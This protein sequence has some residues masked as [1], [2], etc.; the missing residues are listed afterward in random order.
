VANAHPLSAPEQIY[1]ALTAGRFVEVEQ[2]YDKLMNDRTRD[3]RGEYLFEQFVSQTPVYSSDDAKSEDY[4]PKVD[5]LTARWL[6][7]SPNSVIAAITR[8]R[9]LLRRAEHLDATKGSW[10]DVDRLVTE[11][12]DVMARSR[13]RAAADPNWQALN[14]RLAR[15]AGV[16]H[17][18]IRELVRQ[19][20]SVDPYPVLLWEEAAVA[21][22]TDCSSTDNLL[23]LMRLAVERTG[24][25]EGTT[26]YAR[27]FEAAN[28]LYCGMENDPFGRGHLDWE[29][30]N[31]SLAELKVRYPAAYEPNLHG[32]LACLAGDLKTTA[33]ALRNAGVRINGLV[34][35]HWGGKPHLERCK[36]WVIDA[37]LRTTI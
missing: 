8:A 23:W 31:R 29:T 11:A 7:H 18:R 34:W 13:L 15:D 22:R 28:S 37:G 5:A 19:A 20:A 21:L 17:K 33:A 10:K 12:G 14:L 2:Y 27:V 26:M 30:M 32:A 25:R 36:K 3:E 6:A 35:E 9:A 1:A 4:W 24:Q 16:P